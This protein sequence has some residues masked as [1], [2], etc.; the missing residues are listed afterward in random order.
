VLCGG[1]EV[2]QQAAMMG[3][4]RAAWRGALFDEILPA[5][6]AARVPEVPWVENSPTG[7]TL[8]FS[9]SEGVTHYYGVGAYLRPLE[10]ARRAGVR[11]TSECL[12]FA[13]VPVQSTVDALLGEGEV[14]P[15]HPRWKA[16]VPRDAGTSWDFDDVRE[17]YL[18]LIYRV[19]PVALRR[20]DGQRWLDLSRAVTGEVMAATFAEWRRSGSTCKGALVWT[21]QDLWPG[22][23]W[24]VIDATGKPKPAYW[25]L[26]RALQP[27]ALTTTD[28]GLDG[29]RLCVH[30]DVAEPLR[31][32]VQLALYRNGEVP[33]ARGARA[34]EAPARGDLSIAGD[35][36]FDGFHDLAYAY[37]FGPPGHDLA[38]ASL[39]D[40]GGRL[41]AQAFHFPLGQPHERRDDIGLEARV[42]RAAAGWE[43]RA[44]S[45]RFA[46]SIELEV[47]G[48]EPDDDWFHLEPGV[49]RSISLRG[50]TAQPRVRL[51][52]LNA[53]ESVRAVVEAP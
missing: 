43:L 4:P 20:V 38:V 48:A 42:V 13:N 25:F 24:G 21:L 32:E 9:T 47:E 31:G 7:G 23:G 44:R 12:A 19:D 11:F 27:R 28:E 2:E 52:A 8:P 41:L 53:F 51:Q 50:A 46:Q 49:E 15:H 45:R 5:A 37:R 16:R 30:N 29:L 40:E 35:S 33:V 34:V 6:V 17:H 26:R 18:G 1:S 36:L 22:A 3:Q 10:D 14:A 39:R